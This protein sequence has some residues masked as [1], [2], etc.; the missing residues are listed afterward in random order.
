MAMNQNEIKFLQQLDVICGS[1]RIRKSFI[2]KWRKINIDAAINNTPNLNNKQ[3]EE[4][5]ELAKELN[6]I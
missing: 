3:R 1:C 5:R 2:Q 4:L 6:I